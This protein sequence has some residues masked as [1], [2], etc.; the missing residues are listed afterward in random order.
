MHKCMAETLLWYQTINLCWLF[1]D[2]NKE[3]LLWR[4]PECSSDGRCYC[5]LTITILNIETQPLMPTVMLCQGCQT[6]SQVV[7]VWKVK[8]LDDNFPVLAEDVTKATKVGPI[9]SKVH[10]FVLNGWPG[11]S[12]E[13][14]EVFKP[15]YHRR[16]ELR[17]MGC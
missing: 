3:Y 15:F 17:I 2:K 13:I 11:N 1:L 5:R 10:Q 12:D 16:D 7:R 14:P 9:L 8:F 6:L 4:L